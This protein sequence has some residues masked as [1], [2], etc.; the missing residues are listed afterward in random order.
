MQDKK[1]TWLIFSSFAVKTSK[2]NRELVKAVMIVSWFEYPSMSCE[3][4]P[5]MSDLTI[6]EETLQK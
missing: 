2:L 4:H 6:S 3:A 1:N 5:E